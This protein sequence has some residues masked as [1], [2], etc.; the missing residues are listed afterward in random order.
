MLPTLCFDLDGTVADLYNVRGWLEALQIEDA[1]PYYNAAERYDLDYLNDLLE[2]YKAY[3]GHIVV[4]TWLAKG[5]LSEGFKRASSAA[6]MLWLRENLPAIKDVRTLEYGTPKWTCVQSVKNAI[7]FDDELPNRIQWQRQGGKA[8]TP[9][10]M[11][12]TI[13]R[14]LQ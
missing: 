5:E 3:G 1:M 7:L 6:K 11:L 14:L 10:H 2:L 12:R 4:L 13:E 8:Y 9:S